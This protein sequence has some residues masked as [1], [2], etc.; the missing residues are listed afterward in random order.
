VFVGW[1]GGLCSY[2]LIGFYYDRCSTRDE[3]DVRGR[4]AEAFIVNRIGTWGRTGDAA[5]F[6]AT[7]TLD[8]QGILGKVGTL[9]QGCALWRRCSCSWGVRKSAQIP[10]YVWLPTRWR[11]RRRC[12]LLIHAATMVTA[13]VYVTCR[14]APLYL[15]S[16]TAMTT[17]AV[18]GALTAMFAA[19]SAWP[20]PISRRC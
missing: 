19:A 14:M 20:R 7:G 15:M 13:G 11:A 8:I 12:R 18:I 10:L 4:G 9:G 6:A 16:Q 1:E 2:L 3:D 17:V 5:V